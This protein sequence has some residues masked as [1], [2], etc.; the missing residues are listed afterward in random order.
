MQI[1]EMYAVRRLRETWDD[2]TAEG[3]QYYA[4]IAHGKHRGFAMAEK[5]MREIQARKVAAE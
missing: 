4:T 5:R 1:D 3:V 2:L